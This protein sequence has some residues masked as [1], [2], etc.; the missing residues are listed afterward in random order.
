[1]WSQ[2]V[3]KREFLDLTCTNTFS[4]NEKCLF[5]KDVHKEKHTVI[6]D[7]EILSTYRLNPNS[8]FFL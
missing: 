1:M 8:P 6:L 7:K 5:R 2:K 4:L 3:K